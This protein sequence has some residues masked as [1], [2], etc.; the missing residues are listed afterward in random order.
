MGHEEAVH[1]LLAA[2]V[3]L[4]VDLAAGLLRLNFYR[5]LPLRSPGKKH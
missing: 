1:F 5:R 3:V 4:P 2:A